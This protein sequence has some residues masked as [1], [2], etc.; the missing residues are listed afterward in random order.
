MNHTG[1]GKQKMATRQ[2]EKPDLMRAALSWPGF[3][4]ALPLTLAGAIPALAI[5]LAGGSCRRLN[6]A[7]PAWLIQGRFGDWLLQRHPVGAVN[8]MAIGHLVIAQSGAA[9]ARI[10]RH[11]LEH[12]RQ[13]ARWGIVFP[14]AYLIASGWAMARGGRAYWDNGFEVAARR[15]EGGETDFLGQ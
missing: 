1:L 3:L 15:A 13:A 11:E 12:V 2:R 6:D 5:V 14:L 9:S 10:L 4:W 7:P 8:A